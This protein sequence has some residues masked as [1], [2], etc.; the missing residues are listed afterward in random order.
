VKLTPANI[1]RL[2]KAAHIHPYINEGLR[3]ITIGD[4]VCVRWERPMG[5]GHKSAEARAYCVELATEALAARGF[6]LVED[7]DLNRYHVTE[8]Q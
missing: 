5:G 1:N 2:L 7:A 6:T 4:R 3:A 8:S